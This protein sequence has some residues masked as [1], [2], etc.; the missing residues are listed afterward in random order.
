[1]VFTQSE[2]YILLLVFVFGAAFT[3]SAQFPFHFWL[4]GAME[5]PT[6]VSTYL[7]SATMVKAGIYLLLRFSPLLA[8][9]DYW[10]LTL[11]S[12]GG[13]TMIYAAFHTFFRTDMKGVL[14]Y[15]T[16]SALG[17]MVFL[18]GLGSEIAMLAV[19]I[20]ILVHAMYKATLFLI[21]GVVDHETGTRDLTQ[22]G[23][24]SK[25]ILPVAIAGFLA[26]FS[27]AGIPLFAGF[28]GKDLV[29]EAT[30][31]HSF[32][33]Y[34]LTFV[35]FLTHAFLAYAGYVVGIKPFIGQLPTAFQKVHLPS[36]LL[37]IPPLILA[38][39]GLI[40]GLFPQ[41]ILGDFINSSI[42]QV[43]LN[44]QP[45]HLK[46]WHG[47]NEVLIWSLATIT[48]GV[49]LFYFLKPSHEKVTKIAKLDFLAPIQIFENFGLVFEKAS[50]IW[51]NFFQN[52][53]LRNYVLTI[54]SVLT[55]FIG[56]S[57]F[58]HANLHWSFN[59]VQNVTFYEACILIIMVVAILMTVFSSSRLT[60]VAAMG[61]IGYAICLLF[62]FYSAPD[63]AMTQFTI[64]TLT[65]I[66]F[67][68]VLYRL[69]KYLKLSENTFRIRDGII[70]LIFGGLITI[71]AME[72]LHEP[73]KTLTGDFYAQ[74][75]YLLAKGK[76]VVNVILVDFR[77]IDTMVEITVLV[78]AALGVFGLLKLRVR[79]K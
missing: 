11:V 48:L 33:A 55:C 26:A 53:Y 35:A 40:V 51:T 73:Q 34:F 2:F 18:I 72:V 58:C 59:Q 42:S 78:I 20:F 77:G 46:I 19:L 75:A 70:A 54:I 28:I 65:V 23:G 36:P 37:Y 12:I 16:I 74:N 5:A 47:W 62:V 79:N 27:N 45:I 6:P 69:P 32:G 1:M 49:L 76:N 13:F 15:S 64:D 25:V 50:K 22:L 14:A 10:H 61:V 38:I 60:A 8:G 31:H 63:L 41:L 57:L 17:I 39:A 67:V 7:H 44:A 29:Y 52:G 66:L 9:H 21:T 68:L 24:L 4:P 43:Y 56:Y 71:L 30:L 3:K